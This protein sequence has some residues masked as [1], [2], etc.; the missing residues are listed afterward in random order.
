MRVVII[1]QYCENRGDEAAGTAL[2]RNLLAN[3]SVTQIDIIYNSANKLDIDDDRIK[4]RNVDLR[5]KNV[6][7]MG[8]LRYLL[9]RKTF[10]KNSSFAND[11]MKEMIKTINEADYIYV[12]P[13][14]A[15]IGIYKDWAFLLRLL[16]VVME[17][18]TPIFCL[19]TIN[20][21]GNLV[22]DFLARR[23]LRNSI[24]Y[25]R[26]ERSLAYLKSIG[27]DAELGVDT[28]FSEQP[29]V[30][31]RQMNCIGLV[32]TL[33]G[34][35]PEFKGRDMSKEVLENIVPGIAQYC[36]EQGYDIE[37]IPHTAQE[38]ETRY[39]QQIL[40]E[41]QKNGMT[42]ESLIFRSDV[43]TSDDYDLALASKRFVVGMRY[44]SIVLS[45]KNA[46]PF[47]ALA[48]E[49][50]MKEVCRYTN[51]EE[52]YLNL[53]D[54]LTAED[55]YQ[56]MKLVDT[57]RET[58]EDKLGTVYTESLSKLSRLPLKELQK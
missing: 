23:V 26:E 16:F 51:C 47:V 39:I 20:A 5:L 24:V 33:L 54:Q 34:W 11:A 35:H 19:N 56:K 55:V 48:Y 8:I 58:L 22:F 30:A 53:Q 38:D 28:A 3:P 37:I 15:S 41:L 12:T 42:K 17:K 18:K 40:S 43:V 1:N 29:L 45:A 31:D 13:C 21:S 32:V 9:L 7:K 50:K 57:T 27:V 25:V 6:G 36:L 10:L 44:H 52:A 49:N 46:I 2:I 14:G 4:H